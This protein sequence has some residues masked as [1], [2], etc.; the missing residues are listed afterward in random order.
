M[1]AFRVTKAERGGEGGEGGGRGGRGTNQWRKLEGE[2]QE[3][4]AF[5]LL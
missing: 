1:E 4:E 2:T 5:Y 3:Q